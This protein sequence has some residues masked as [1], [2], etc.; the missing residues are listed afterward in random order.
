MNHTVR[1]LALH[2]DIAAPQEGRAADGTVAILA[3][4]SLVAKGNLEPAPAEHLARVE[5]S[6]EPAT[7]RAGRYLFVQGLLSR[8][9]RAARDPD[10]AASEPEWRD[11]AEAVWLESLWRNQTFAS[12]RFYVRILTE[13]GKTVYQIFRE[14][15]AGE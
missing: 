10:R 12:D 8:G 11:A 14:I 7:I 2:R 9:E 4:R 15:E 1:A 13:D 5:E 3:Y 6:G